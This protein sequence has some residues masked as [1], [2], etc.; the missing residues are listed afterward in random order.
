MSFKIDGDFMKIKR[1]P[2]NFIQ[3][4]IFSIIVCKKYNLKYHPFCPIGYGE[5]NFITHK[6]I[7]NPFDKDFLTIFLHEIG[8]HVH[9]KIV[10][11]DRFLY[12]VTSFK[13]VNCD[14]RCAFK[15]LE[16]EAFATRFAIKTGIVEKRFL[17]S[18]FYTYTSCL[19]S[20]DL[21]KYNLFSEAVDLVH[22]LHQKIN[23]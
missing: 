10:N 5:Y 1:K 14:N 6:V 17:L 9:D 21:S 4:I 22:K 15:I 13:M 7:V 18:A 2:N 20:I 3:N 11:Y 23:K 19:F 12:D 8:H 16:A